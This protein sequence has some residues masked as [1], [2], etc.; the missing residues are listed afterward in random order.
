MNSPEGGIGFGNPSGIDSLSWP[1]K[2][3]LFYENGFFGFFA[4]PGPRRWSF[5]IGRLGSNGFWMGDYGGGGLGRT[6]FWRTLEES[7]KGLGKVTMKKKK[8]TNTTHGGL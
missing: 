2:R 6:P 8:T 1:L 5:G 3:R 4:G 7:C